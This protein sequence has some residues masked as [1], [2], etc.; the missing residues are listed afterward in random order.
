[1]GEIVKTIWM[2]FSNTVGNLKHFLIA[3]REEKTMLPD[4]II[5]DRPHRIALV[6]VENITC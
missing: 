4:F 1:M 3:R 2:S 5:R 6:R